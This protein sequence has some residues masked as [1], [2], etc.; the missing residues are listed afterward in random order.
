[1]LLEPAAAK[2]EHVHVLVV[3]V[4]GLHQVQTAWHPEQSGLL[5]ALDEPAVGL[6][7]H[8]QLPT[9]VRR[10]HEEIEAAIAIEVVGD[11]AAGHVERIEPDLAGD[12]AEA[13]DLLF[14]LEGLR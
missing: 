5:G 4:V 6:A 10:R 2:H 8:A 13:R 7:I 12:V 11:G 14:R 9:R 3:V 1:M